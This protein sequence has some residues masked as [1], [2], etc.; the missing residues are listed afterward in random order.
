MWPDS[1]EFG[2]AG[3]SL[4]SDDF[5]Y[6][7]SYP[8]ESIMKV[9]ISLL[10]ISA[11]VI[12]LAG[13]GSSSDESG[14]GLTDA[15]S[16]PIVM[17]EMPPM[18]DD[19]H[20]HA[21]HGPHGGELVEL[22]KEDFH[23][24]LVHGDEGIELYVLDGSATEMVPIPAEK[25]VVSLKHEGQVQSFDLPAKPAE[26]D[27]QGQASRFMSTDKQLDEWLD[28][29]AEGAVVIQIQGKSYTGKITH[30]HDHEG[31]NH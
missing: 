14:G 2:F 19:A 21:E 11:V 16:A 29:G 9:A 1:P 26:S 8:E 6:G 17:D 3:D 15:G 10:T 23:A 25:L 31:H 27:E 5:S 13:C 12:T 7:S 30:D 18:L 4:K 24:E 28:A 20:G 22:G